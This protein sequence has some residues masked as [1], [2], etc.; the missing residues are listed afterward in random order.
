MS[1]RF[2]DIPAHAVCVAYSSNT[3]GLPK[4]VMLSH[5][6]LVVNA[7]HP[8]SPQIFSVARSP[9]NILPFFP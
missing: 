9:C 7:D 2:V 6:N 4:G 1:R 8:S 5:R 3:T